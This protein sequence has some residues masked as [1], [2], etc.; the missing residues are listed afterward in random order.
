MTPHVKKPPPDRH[1]L[2]ISHGGSSRRC[3]QSRLLLASSR[4]LEPGLQ[5]FMFKLLSYATGYCLL[6]SEL[7]N[8]EFLV[9][10]MSGLITYDDH[11][12]FDV[13]SNYQW[14][15][16]SNRCKQYKLFHNPA[17]TNS[18]FQHHWSRLY[19]RD[20]FHVTDGCSELI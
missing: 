18:L 16:P 11:Y 5:R 2:H 13:F 9:A 15:S 8:A 6:S 12:D 4:N 19:H 14:I 10:R 20:A 17:D 1:G 3:G 7:L